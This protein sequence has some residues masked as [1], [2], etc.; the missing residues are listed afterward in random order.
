[1]DVIP[2][3]VKI[4]ALHAGAYKVPTNGEESDGTLI[5]DSTTM[6]LVKVEAGGKTGIGYSYADV[7]AAHLISSSLR[8]AVVGQNALDIENIF[9]RL[10]H[11]IRNNGDSGIA[12]MAVSAID[13][14]MWDLKGKLLEMPV[15]LLLGRASDEILVYGSGGFTSY[16]PDQ[17][18][19][20][21]GGWASQGLKQVKMKIGR[22]PDD[23]MQRIRIAREAIGQDTA[24]FVD[25]NG[26]YTVKQAIRMAEQ[27]A[28][29]DVRWYEEPVQ[30][31]DYRGT[32][33]VRDACPAEMDVALGEYGYNLRDFRR[34]LENN[35]VDVLQADATRCGGISG[36]LRA[37]R[38]AEAFQVPFSFHCAPSVHLHA[39]LALPGFYT[40]EYFYDH[41]RIEKMLFDGFREPVNGKLSADLGRPGLGLE[42]KAQDAEKYKLFYQ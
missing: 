23:D 18:I 40:G 22:D 19:H 33:F 28:A 29:Y 7:S 31:G 20:Q 41:I 16:S 36:F 6:V 4:D 35:A 2:D 38:L 26:A 32:A 17:L 8:D 30:F 10:H 12:M 15:A 39:A 21:L 13:N 24:L 14:A 37:G 27:F 5:W 25:A 1:M 3:E 9:D 42:F 34:I 11:N